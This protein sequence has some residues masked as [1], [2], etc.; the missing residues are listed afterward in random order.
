MGTYIYNVRRRSINITLPDG[1]TV[2]AFIAKYLAKP[3]WSFFN[4][5]RDR[6]WQLALAATEAAWRKSGETPEYVVWVH[7]RPEDGDQIFR[8]QPDRLSWNDNNKAPGE[9]IG[10]LKRVRNRW[11][12]VPKV[13]N[14]QAAVDQVGCA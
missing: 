8:W 5:D 12:L 3:R 14:E 7:E 11:T 10:T 9:Q 13:A 4:R 1:L 2:K 6:P